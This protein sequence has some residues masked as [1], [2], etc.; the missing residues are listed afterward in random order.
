MTYYKSKR[1]IDGKVRQ[2]IVDGNEKI[3]SINPS[4]DEL[5]ILEE[6][7]Y[8]K[9]RKG[10]SKNYNETN[11]CPMI[12]EDGTVC[13][14]KLISGKTMREHDKEEKETGRWIC[15]NCYEKYDS[16]SQHNILKSV[17]SHR[18]GNL[19]PNSN[20]AKADNFEELTH[21]WKGVKILSKENDYYNL[22]ERLEKTDKNIEKTDKNIEELLKILEKR[23]RI[24]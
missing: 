19:D 16:N 18:T 20:H 6:E 4:K 11:I 5:K 3:V 13:K 24:E 22:G 10:G 9:R 7:Q 14:N 8:T 1:Y 2:I 23:Q 21:R 17:A 12:K 15:T